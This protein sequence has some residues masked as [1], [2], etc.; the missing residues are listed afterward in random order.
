[1]TAGA[2]LMTGAAGYLGRRVAARLAAQGWVV[3][4]ILR[5]SSKRDGL[6]SMQVHEIEDV[7][8]CEAIVRSV[9]P[10]AVIHVAAPTAKA[11]VRDVIE[12]AVGLPAALAAGAEALASPPRMVET[13][14]WWEWDENG[15][16]GPVNLYAAAKTAGRETL[17]QAA[18]R[19]RI[20]LAS[21]IL[22]DVY[23]PSDWRR[24]LLPRLLDAAQ[25]GETV[26]MTDGWQTLDWIHVDDAA[27]AVLATLNAATDATPQIFA[28]G[29]ERMTLRDVVATIIA[30]G[31]RLTADWGA[32]PAPIH[33][34]ARPGAS[35]P[36][37]PGWAAQRKLSDHIAS[38]LAAQL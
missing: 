20:S 9:A 22:H 8:A 3:H 34:R 23:G 13:G 17:A 26:A 7:Y 25:T 24:K 12:A 29:A 5:P 33:Q 37:P 35:F 36:P 18:R 21:V 19:G 15:A 16:H 4:A 32:L 27:A 28:A 30:Q 10:N 2:A 1:M 14:S 31:G 11:N 38:E 6:P